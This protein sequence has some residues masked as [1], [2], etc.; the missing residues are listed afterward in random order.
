VPPAKYAQASPK[1]TKRMA[2]EFARR[3]VTYSSGC[4]WTIDTPYRETAEEARHYQEEG[5]VCVEM[6]AAALFSGCNLQ[7]CAGIERLRHQ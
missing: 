4:A 2:D 5:V 3:G 6:E 1:L 7:V